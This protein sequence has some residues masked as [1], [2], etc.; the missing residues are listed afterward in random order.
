M[1]ARFEPEAEIESQEAA[2]R[3]LAEAVAAADGAGRSLPT[4]GVSVGV[5]YHG[6]RHQ[7][8][9]SWF[10]AGPAPECFSDLVN[11]SDSAI[12]ESASEGELCEV[13]VRY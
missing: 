9:D 5:G 1:G 8:G 7:L 12:C 4:G 11:A 13:A 3:A 10:A 6:A 2:D